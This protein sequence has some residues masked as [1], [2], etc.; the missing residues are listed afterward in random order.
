[1][2]SKFIYQDG[3]PIELLD[4]VLTDSGRVGKVAAYDT[5]NGLPYVQIAGKD[6][7]GEVHRLWYSPNMLKKH[8]T[9]QVTH[10]EYE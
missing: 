5:I 10:Q 6:K 2:K 4:Q 7:E 3:S 1:M 8:R 9:L